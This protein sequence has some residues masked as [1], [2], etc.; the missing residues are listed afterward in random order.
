MKLIY[1]KSQRQLM[2]QIR[3]GESPNQSKSYTKIVGLKQK[4]ETNT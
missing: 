4:F 3:P 2:Y 1:E